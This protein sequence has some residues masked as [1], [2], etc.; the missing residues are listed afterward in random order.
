MNYSC[1][2]CGAPVR[3]LKV[4]A[5]VRC[6]CELAILGDIIQAA[7]ESLLLALLALREGRD[8]DAHEF[9]CESWSLKQTRQAS[10]A[11]LIAAAMQRDPIE[12]ARWMRRRARFSD[13]P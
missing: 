10:A 6:G 13:S 4:A 11:G 9:A 5:C 1:P 8:R 3:S 12:I 2:S 7:R